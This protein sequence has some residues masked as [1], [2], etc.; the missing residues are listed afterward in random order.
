MINAFRGNIKNKKDETNLS[1]DTQKIKGYGFSETSGE[2]F[3]KVILYDAPGSGTPNHPSAT[4][5]K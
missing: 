1:E 5:V 3:P 2:V 4:Y